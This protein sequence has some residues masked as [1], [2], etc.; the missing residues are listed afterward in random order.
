MEWKEW[1]RWGKP[2]QCDSSAKEKDSLVLLFIQF[3]SGT[4]LMHHFQSRN[5]LLVNTCSKCNSQ[6]SRL[7]LASLSRSGCCMQTKGLEEARQC[8]TDEYG[9]HW[10]GITSDI[11]LRSKSHLCNLS[12]SAVDCAVARL[13]LPADYL[14]AA[15]LLLLKAFIATGRLPTRSAGP[16]RLWHIHC[17]NSEIASDTAV[18]ITRNSYTRP[19]L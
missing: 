8:P 2:A 15:C 10:G 17:Y 14:L 6:L 13:L 18:M 5:E 1:K 16:L 9:A 19:N 4:Q 3:H 12:S 7:Q 11:A